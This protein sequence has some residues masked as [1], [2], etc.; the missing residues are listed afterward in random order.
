MVLGPISFENIQSE[1]SIRLENAQDKS[2]IIV[3]TPESN[4]NV[5]ERLNEQ[6]NSCID[7]QD[8]LNT[9]ESTCD[10]IENDVSSEYVTN[11]AETSSGNTENNI[12]ASSKNLLKDLNT[13][14]SYFDKE[15]SA[16]RKEFE[17]YSRSSFQ[18]H[19]LFDDIDNVL[20]D[21]ESL[22]NQ[23]YEVLIVA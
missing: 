5:R 15:S 16:I 18:S 10:E 11:T 17:E 22:L 12:N 13:T 21:S 1:S 3:N 20:N 7:A 2:N 8:D 14:D 19:A 6:S 23:V 4:V 9:I